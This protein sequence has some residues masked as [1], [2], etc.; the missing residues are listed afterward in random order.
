MEAQH[1]ARSSARWEYMSLI[2]WDDDPKS[3]VSSDIEDVEVLNTLGAEG[4]ELVCVVPL[5]R[6][7]VLEMAYPGQHPQAPRISQARRSLRGSRPRGGRATLRVCVR[8]LHPTRPNS[9]C[10]PRPAVRCAT[11]ALTALAPLAAELGFTVRVV[12]ISGDP[13]L[14]ARY[15]E[16]I[17]VGELGGRVV[18]KFRL[19]EAR[20]RRMWARGAGG[21]RRVGRRGILSGSRV[22]RSAMKERER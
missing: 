4:W 10:S 11:P 13:D 2:V 16:R 9:A 3:Q 18:F 20:L 22:D 12:D 7:Q 6:T 5:A 1:A 19:D 21:R 15:R 17:P 14:E 8:P